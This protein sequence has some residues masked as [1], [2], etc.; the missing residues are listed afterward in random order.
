LT[1]DSRLLDLA[2]GAGEVAFG[3]A[4]HVGSLTGV[5][6]EQPMLDL[7]R[8]EALRAGID[9]RWVCSDIENM[10]ADIGTFDLAT[11]GKAHWYLPREQTL[12]QLEKLLA[13]TGQVLVCSTSTHDEQSGPWAE[14]YRR[15]RNAWRRVGRP[16]IS[17]R[18]FMAGSPFAYT[19]SVIAR[20]RRSVPVE[21]LLKRALAF[22]GTSPA[23]LGPDKERYLGEIRA[24]IAPYAVDGA[25]PE[26]LATVGN[27]FARQPGAI[28]A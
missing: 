15:T 5:E 21:D 23:A 1:R 2:C 28:A 14:A 13:P 6:R 24:A 16:H 19:K 7:A 11:I 22:A 18:E 27:I 10:P 4:R 26:T 3:F 20:A 9:I 17:A 8:A 12:Q 25:L